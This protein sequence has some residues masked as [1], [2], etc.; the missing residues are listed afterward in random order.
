VLILLIFDPVGFEIV[1]TPF[2][3]ETIERAKLFAGG[4]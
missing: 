4:A 2:A 3:G 1:D